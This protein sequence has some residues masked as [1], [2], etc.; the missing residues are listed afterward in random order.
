M[1]G[2]GGGGGGGF[3]D[4]DADWCDCQLDPSDS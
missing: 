1:G 3:V 4:G 2:G